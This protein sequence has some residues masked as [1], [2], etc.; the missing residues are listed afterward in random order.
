MADDATVARRFALDRG[1]VQELMLDNEA[2]GLVQRVEFC[3][4]R[5]WALTEAGRR[6]NER[7]LAVEL[8]RAR[9]RPSVAASHQAFLPLNS[10]LLDA[11]TRWQ[12]RPS[13]SDPMTANDHCDWKWDERVLESLAGL[14]RRVR[15]IEERLTAELTRFGGY[16]DRRDAALAR[17]ER[18]ERRWVDDPRIDSCHTVWF[19]LHE[20]LLATLGFARGA[21]A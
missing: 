13:P 8:D 6:E 17:A 9:A 18:G 11:I 3:D 14:S 4:A 21:E 12:M 16:T 20:D 1:V 7:L 19:E 15:P 10:R 5:G 2:S